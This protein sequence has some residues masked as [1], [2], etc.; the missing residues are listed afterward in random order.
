MSDTPIEQMSF[1]QAMAELESVI[2]R[3]EGNQVA[4]DD[5]ISLSERG[6]QLKQHCEAKLRAAEEK[7]AKI[8]FGA[9]GKPDGLKPLEG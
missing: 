4:L 3:L 6:A 7:I 2:T 5:T 8:T 1:E 9:D